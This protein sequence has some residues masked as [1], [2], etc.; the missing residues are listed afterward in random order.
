M[1]A[2]VR[3]RGSKLRTHSSICLYNASTHTTEKT[4]HRGVDAQTRRRDLNLGRGEE[5]DGTLRRRLYPRLREKR[6]QT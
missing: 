1:S 2:C 4:G 5:Q 6:E 3:Q